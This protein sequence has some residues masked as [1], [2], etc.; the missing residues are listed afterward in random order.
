MSRFCEKFTNLLFCEMQ[1]LAKGTNQNFLAILFNNNFKRNTIFSGILKHA[2]FSTNHY[3]LVGNYYYYSIH[4]TD[5]HH[6]HF[7]WQP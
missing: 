2:I 5:H 3:G 7:Y 1:W 6:H 4:Q